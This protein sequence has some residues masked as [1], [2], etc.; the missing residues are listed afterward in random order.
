MM[1]I[2]VIST[3]KNE[4]AALR[5]LLESLIK[6]TRQPDEV[7]FCDGGS[8]DD[9]VAILQEY[10][11]RLPL[12]IIIAPGTNISQG[13]NRAIAAAAGPIIAGADA[14]VTLAP[15]WLD[16][17]VRPIEQHGAAVVAGWFEAAPLT[18]FEIVMGA[19]TLPDLTDVDPAEFLPSS[20]SVA[21]HKQA[22]QTVGGYP[23]WL[24]FGED[25]IFDLALRQEYGPISF[26]PGAVV[27]FRPRGNMRA[28]ARQYYL[29]AR[30][31]G[32]ANLW[33]KRHAVRYLTYM[34]GLP[35]IVD[36]I[37]RGNGFGWL[38]MLAGGGLYCRRPAQRLAP[39]MH[40]RS[41]AAKVRAFSLI[42]II[43]LVGD[44]AKMIGYPVG[45][46]WRWRR[47]R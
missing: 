5:P 38:L 45:L 47:S 3:V 11:N 19:T 29:Y 16:E 26:A 4:G 42:P 24:D 32:K 39:S 17:L 46:L 7:V 15:E 2:S 20:R 27:Y 30:G 43:R 13:R 6:Q 22:W 14:G 35:L 12:K 37:R 1:N 36:L 9:T 25:L 40:G 21:Y 41:T 10:Q 31:D 44:V 28:F 34:I 23:E 33:P 18:D 8:T